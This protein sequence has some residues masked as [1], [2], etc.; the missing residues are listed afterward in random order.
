MEFSLKRVGDMNLHH[1][2]SRTDSPIQLVFTPGVLG[3]EVWGHQ[4]RYFSKRFDTTAYNTTFSNRGFDDQMKALET[5]I[6]QEDV[7]NAVLIGQGPG[8]SLIQ[9]FEEDEDVVGTVLT[10]VQDD[11]RSVPRELYGIGKKLGCME[12]K[13]VKKFFFSDITD[14]NVV[15][16]FVEDLDLVEYGDYRSFVENYSIRTPVKQS[17]IIHA[18]EDR[19]S[20]RQCARDVEG[21]NLSV[22]DAGTFSFY[23]KPQEYNKAL[24][25]FL[26]GVER[27]VEEREVYRAASEN[28]SLKEFEAEEDDRKVKVRNDSRPDLEG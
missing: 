4:I 7:E 10:S 25:D 1:F 18:T 15:K 22:I 5:V 13:L 28:R 9:A 16:N 19:F 26:V 8:N 11:Y 2:E 27:L 6:S 12:P 20:D 14:Y 3:P 24:H 21:A 23:E 17:M